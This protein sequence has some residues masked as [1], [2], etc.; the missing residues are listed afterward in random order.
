MVNLDWK[1]CIKKIEKVY[2]NEIRCFD[3]LYLEDCKAVEFFNIIASL[4]EKKNADIFEHCSFLKKLNPA[5]CEWTAMLVK[6]CFLSGHFPENLKTSKVIPLYKTGKTNY[7]NNYSPISIFPAVA[8][9]F[10]K[11]LFS[12]VSN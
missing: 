6:Q 1:N 5:I 10:E 11:L 2:H 4:K 9:I 3:T 7:L 12:R 8:K